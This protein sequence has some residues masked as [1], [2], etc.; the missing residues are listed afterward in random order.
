VS[1]PLA[2]DLQDKRETDVFSTFYGLM[3]TAREGDIM[4]VKD[5]LASGASIIETNELGHT[6]LN[7]AP[8]RDPLQR[9]QPSARRVRNIQ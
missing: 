1:H 4:R 7:L 8:W 9:G 6:A 5:L 3:G 2:R